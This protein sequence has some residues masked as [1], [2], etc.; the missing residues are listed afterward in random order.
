MAFG[1]TRRGSISAINVTPLVDVML[2]LLIIFMV[3]ATLVRPKDEQ[4]RQ[5]DMN[6]PATH[7]EPAPA[8]PQE[9]LIL[10]I[11]RGLVVRLGDQTVVDCSAALTSQADDRFEPCFL[12]IQQQIAANTQ[13]TER[14]SLYILADLE[15]PYGF[16]VGTLHRI[17][18]A[19]VDRVGM[20]TNPEFLTQAG[21]PDAP[22]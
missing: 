8:N 12:Q 6:L 16:V 21:T 13:V 5:V 22:Q 19:G 2:V 11:D 14:G 7:T 17:R 15:V 10:H 1:P 9:N 18:L 4:E 20:V 3:T